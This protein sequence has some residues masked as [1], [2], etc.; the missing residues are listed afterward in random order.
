MTS[1][2]WGNG[3]G[4][5]RDANSIRAME[6]LTSSAGDIPMDRANPRV[7]PVQ[8]R[9]GHPV[10][11]E[12]AGDIPLTEEVVGP[13]SLYFTGD[14]ALDHEVSNLIYRGRVV[15]TLQEGSSKA[16]ALASIESRLMALRPLY[17]AACRGPR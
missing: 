16:V 11:S 12:P 15:S 2:K 8:C 7:S 5:M 1:P 9:S 17:Q 10:E 4:M 3:R 14:T 13:E 6:I